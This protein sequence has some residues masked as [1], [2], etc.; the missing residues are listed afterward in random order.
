[1]ED[2]KG[3]RY[4]LEYDFTGLSNSRSEVIATKIEG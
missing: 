4:V 1:M 3:E 2:E